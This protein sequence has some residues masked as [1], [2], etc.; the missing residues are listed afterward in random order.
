MFS[1]N[2]QQ[3]ST[4]VIDLRATSTL[5]TTYPYGCT[6][7]GPCAFGRK[8]HLRVDFR[9]NVFCSDKL[10]SPQ[11][12]LISRCQVKLLSINFFWDIMLIYI[13]QIPSG[14][15]TQLWTDPPF[16]MGKSTMN[17]HFPWL[18]QFTRGQLIVINSD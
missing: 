7:F 8:K 12:N 13:Q 2:Y 15:F 10:T 18:C 1:M 5:Q 11:I 9:A 6:V 16:S 17:G 4:I 14:N 3:L